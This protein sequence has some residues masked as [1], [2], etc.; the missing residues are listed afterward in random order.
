[1]EWFCTEKDSKGTTSPLN[2]REPSCGSRSTSVF[3][4]LMASLSTYLLCCVDHICLCILNMLHFLQSIVWVQYYKYAFTYFYYHLFSKLVP[5]T[6]FVMW[7]DVLTVSLLVPHIIFFFSV[8]VNKNMKCNKSKLIL[9]FNSANWW[10]I[11]NLCRLC[12]LTSGSNQYGSIQGHTAVSSGSLLDDDHWHSVV[13]ERYRRNVNFTLDQHTHSFRTNGEF[14]HLDLDYEVSDR[15]QNLLRHNAT[16]KFTSLTMRHEI[17]IRLGVSAIY[18]H[19]SS[20]QTGCLTALCQFN[21]W[22]KQWSVLRHGSQTSVCIPNGADVHWQEVQHWERL[23]ISL[24][25]PLLSSFKLSF[26][27]VHEEC[28]NA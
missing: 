8:Q 2:S 28:R 20:P 25:P 17:S 22:G 21:A 23:K 6:S 15:S 11:L 12:V 9:T 3:C 19:H 1:M 5:L 10:T 24:K 18:S 27:S 13:V 14:D 4:L 16:I 7:C 26:M